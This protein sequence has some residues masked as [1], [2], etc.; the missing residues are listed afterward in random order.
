LESSLIELKEATTLY[1]DKASVWNNLGLT[2]FEKSEMDNA[3]AEFSKA[4][5]LDGQA[6]HYNNRGLAYFH[7]K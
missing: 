6:V 4:I 7:D 3:A 2:Y 5:K 1:S